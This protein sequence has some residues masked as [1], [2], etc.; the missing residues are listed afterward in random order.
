[1]W[2]YERQQVGLPWLW[3]ISSVPSG[4]PIQ[5]KSCNLVCFR[6]TRSSVLRLTRYLMVMFSH[7]SRAESVDL[8]ES[9]F[10]GCLELARSPVQTDESLNC[11][12]TSDGGLDYAVPIFNTDNPIW[13]PIIKIHSWNI[14]S[15][16]RMNRTEYLMKVQESTL[17]HRPMMIS[18]KVILT[19]DIISFI[20]GFGPISET[21]LNFEESQVDCQV[22]NPRHS[23]FQ[24]VDQSIRSMCCWDLIEVVERST[25]N[26]F[27]TCSFWKLIVQYCRFLVPRGFGPD[28]LT[29]TICWGSIQRSIYRG[30]SMH[31]WTTTLT[32]ITATS[33]FAILN[34]FR[35]S[36]DK[37]Y[38]ETLWKP[39][40]PQFLGRSYGLSTGPLR[41]LYRRRP[42]VLNGPIWNGPAELRYDWEQ[43]SLRQCCRLR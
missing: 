12:S 41:A 16:S 7:T 23:R 30:G 19:A 6:R 24:D 32:S 33:M 43:S 3:A 8:R 37:T 10:R 38:P 42:C 36:S 9:L 27:R 25:A 26:L 31:L 15:I 4:N 5:Y 28:S 18:L 17:P 22:S 1:M 21:W 2:T 40:V 29:S 14:L 35:E 20:D 39:R 11:T 34:P 13:N